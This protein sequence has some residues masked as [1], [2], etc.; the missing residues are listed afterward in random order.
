MAEPGYFSDVFLR[1]VGTILIFVIG[2]GAM[3]SI[4]TFHGHIKTR[5]VDRM[6]MNLGESL[7]RD[8]YLMVSENERIKPGIVNKAILD[9]YCS[10]GC[11]KE[12][13]NVSLGT[14]EWG[15]RFKTETINKKFG[16]F[17]QE[18]SRSFPIFVKAKDKTYPG[19]MEVWVGKRV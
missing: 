19:R 3:Y 9:K 8:K 6:K 18:D 17:Q 14:Y 4:I 10:G 2:F 11:K 12:K 1:A 7:L 16:D 13:L 5:V 15:V